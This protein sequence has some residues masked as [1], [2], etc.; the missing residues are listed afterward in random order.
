MRRFTRTMAIQAM[1]IHDRRDIL[2]VSNGP[3]RSGMIARL[4]RC[5]ASEFIR[6]E[7]GSNEQGRYCGDDQCAASPF[8]FVLQRHACV[9]FA[10]FGH[11]QR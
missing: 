9:G 8:R 1:R 6:R 5:S 4:L 10:A 7:C 11:D 2:V 3:D